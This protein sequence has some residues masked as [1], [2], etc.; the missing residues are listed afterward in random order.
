MG[1]NSFFS[2]S[3]HAY[4]DEKSL[5]IVQ[6]RMLSGKKQITGVYYKNIEGLSTEEISQAV[7]AGILSFKT[8]LR[9]VSIILPSK[10]AITKNI[11]VPSLDEE[12]ISNIIRL[13]AVRHTPYSKEEVIVGHINLDRVL[14]RYTKVLLVIVSNENIRKK[15]DV[16]ELAGCEIESVHLS[17]DVLTKYV[18]SH[19]SVKPAGTPWGLVS[20]EKDF[21]D[22]IIIHNS[23]PHYIRTIPI[24]LDQLDKDATSS[25][26]PL[27]DE[28]KKTC[29][30]YQSEDQGALLKDF[31]IAGVGSSAASTPLLKSLKEEFAV[32]AHLLLIQDK[33][34]LT[35]EAKNAM[36]SAGNAVFLD[37]F[38]DGFSEDGAVVDLLPEDLKTRRSFREKGKEMF[39]AAILILIIL[40]FIVS[41]FLAKIYFRNHYLGEISKNFELKQKEADELDVISEETRVVKQF[42]QRRTV[43]AKVLDEFQNALPPDM[44]L[45]EI[46]M[47][48][49]SHVSIKGTSRLMST[50]FSFVT[51]L[52]NNP[53]F[54][55][56]TSDYTKSRKENDKEVSDFGLSALLED[57]SDHGG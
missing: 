56:V 43:A 34:P 54:K 50:V 33:L 15:T 17:A 12:E 14:E 18:I 20:I 2:E 37:V 29:E 30:A 4:V 25:V 9:R 47:T 7:K 51:Q 31:V 23:K 24:G 21:T 48:A 22:L 40:G 36:I 3:L 42:R 38:A 13:Q 19:V 49:D 35:S 8:L 52:E 53:R 39:T 44:Y 26:K 27:V 16:F 46:S 1:I 10:F 57:M 41:V 6:V 28:F 11:E 55:T 32:D 5:K 45:S